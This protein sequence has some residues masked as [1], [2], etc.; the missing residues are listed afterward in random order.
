M[1]FFKDHQVIFTELNSPLISFKPKD[2]ESMKLNQDDFSSLNRESIADIESFYIKIK[3]QI[4]ETFDFCENVLL[5]KKDSMLKDLNFAFSSQLEFADCF[6]ENIE[7]ISNYLMIDK[8]V[9]ENCGSI[10]HPFK[11]PEVD[12]P[13][14]DSSQTKV[15]CSFANLLFMFLKLF[16]FNLRL[17]NVRKSNKYQEIC[18]LSFE[19]G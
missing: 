8:S 10:I 9:K 19:S 4:N 15:I 7:F 18:V 1:R 13:Q 17:F 6:V 14:S 3:S 11:S 12:S 2:H 16:F 5:Q